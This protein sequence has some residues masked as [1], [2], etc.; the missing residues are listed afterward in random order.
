MTITRARKVRW[1]QKAP[2]FR[3][4]CAL[5]LQCTEVNISTLFQGT[6]QNM[7][8]QRSG[9]LLVSSMNL[10]Q[11]HI[12]RMSCFIN[13]CSY[14]PMCICHASNLELKRNNSKL[15]S[16]GNRYD[17]SPHCLNFHLLLLF[18]YVKQV[19]V[20]LDHCFTVTEC[21]CRKRGINVHENNSSL[22][23]IQFHHILSFLTHT[24]QECQDNTIMWETNSNDAFKAIIKC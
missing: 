21:E 8:P 4:L 23:F 24:P 16:I 17:G 11:E 5:T 1:P 22:L 3:V 20:I 2:N 10:E 19:I 18:I 7:W 15:T 13:A 9:V 12:V 6:G 14:F